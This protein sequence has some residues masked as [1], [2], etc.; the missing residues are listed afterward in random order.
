[1]IQIGFTTLKMVTVH[2]GIFGK[3]LYNISPVQHFF[4]SAL[5]GID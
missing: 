3:I 2:V 5:A 4:S 1:M